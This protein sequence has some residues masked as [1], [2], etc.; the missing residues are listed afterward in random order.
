L[1]PKPMKLRFST[2]VRLILWKTG[3]FIEAEKRLG[4]LH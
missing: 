4:G 3:K 2:V 1:E